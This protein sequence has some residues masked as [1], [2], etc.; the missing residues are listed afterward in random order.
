M[1]EWR[2]SGGGR[3]SPPAYY[4]MRRAGHSVRY[5]LLRWLR[6]N[7]PAGSATTARLS[8]SRRRKGAQRQVHAYSGGGTRALSS[9]PLSIQPLVPG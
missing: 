1:S 8:P 6:T 4:T 9:Q 5:I 2:G 3:P 7:S